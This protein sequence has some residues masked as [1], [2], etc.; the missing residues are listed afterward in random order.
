MVAHDTQAKALIQL[1][2]YPLSYN[3]HGNIPMGHLAQTA[4]CGIANKLRTNSGNMPNT[5][6]NNLITF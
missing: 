5:G 2:A 6:F 3:G 4:S 1:V